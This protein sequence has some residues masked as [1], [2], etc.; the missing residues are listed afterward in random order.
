MYYTST[1]GHF[2]KVISEAQILHIKQ[3]YSIN[4]MGCTDIASAVDRI[5]ISSLKE[6]T[7]GEFHTALLTTTK[8]LLDLSITK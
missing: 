6:C 2:Y 3:D 5:N 8:S 7:E 1:T 4:V